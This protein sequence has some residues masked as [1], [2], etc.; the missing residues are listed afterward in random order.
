MAIPKLTALRFVVGTAILLG[1]YQMQPA[2]N[3]QSAGLEVLPVEHLPEYVTGYPMY[4]AITV[5][6]GAGTAWNRLRFADLTGLHDT[7][8]V[9]MIQESGPGRVSQMPKPVI[10]PEAGM[11]PQ[12]LEPG[13]SRRM[14]AD[15][16]PLVGDIGEGA[17]RV[18]FSYLTP[19]A[20][21]RAA[22]V[23]LHFRKPS[24]GEEALKGSVAPDRG[25]FANWSLWSETCGETPIPADRL[26]S[27]GALTLPLLERYLFCGP[28]PLESIEP[29]VVDVL[30]GLYTPERDALKAELYQA[31]GDRDAY[32]RLRQTILAS[33][34]GL[35]WWV[36]MMDGGG[37]FVKS[38]SMRPKRGGGQ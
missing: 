38:L 12:R 13:E 30:T 11:F 33:A 15:V 3:A 27:A 8:G 6:A 28:E 21:Y 20:A 7:I 31:R 36:H 4:V 16:S 35:A 23:V 32:E 9:E 26:R 29:S 14:L 10:E 17:W 1:G 25:R 5:R 18:R 34:P 37:A 24:P 22:P 19:K 2:A